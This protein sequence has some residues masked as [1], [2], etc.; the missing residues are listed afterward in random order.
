[1]IAELKPNLA[2]E[3]RDLI[4]AEIER[5]KAK[6]HLMN[7]DSNTYCKMPPIN[8]LDDFGGVTFFFFALEDKKDYFARLEHYGVRDGSKHVAV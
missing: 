7:L 3:E 4:L 6:Y 5:L 1:M 8:G 2:N